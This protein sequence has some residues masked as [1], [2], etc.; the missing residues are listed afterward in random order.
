[1]SIR[2]VSGESQMCFSATASFVTAALTGAAGIAAISRTEERRELP[3][4]AIPL[5]FAVQQGVEG[6]LW[7]TLPGEPNGVVCSALTHTFL[8]FALLFWPIIAPL[9]VL[10]I[11]TDPWRRKLIMGC[12]AI[13]AGV[14][15][16]LLSVFLGSAHQALLKDGHIVYR[17]LPP[18]DRSVGIF[19]L[20]AT[21]L[22]PALSTHRAINILSIL[23][24]VGSVV[25]WIAYWEA[26]VSVWC[27][28]AAASSVVILMH[29]ERAR[30][31]RR[32][33]VA[34]KH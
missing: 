34:T 23:V 27:F 12:A 26:L 13:G 1:M 15:L 24:V 31:V 2:E 11:E 20:L 9:A 6:A 30:E 5:V 33:N 16:Y 25:A 28:F 8:F 4:A 19:Y 21:G 32:S 7:L 22:G 10:A 18:P 17:S 14:A 3:L 29:F